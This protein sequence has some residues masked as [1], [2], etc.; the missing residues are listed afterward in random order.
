MKRI[1]E[2]AKKKGVEAEILMKEHQTINIQFQDGKLSSVTKNNLNDFSLRVLNNGKLGI[3]YG[4]KAKNREKL[5]D[6]AIDLSKAGS[7][8]DFPF[9]NQ[10]KF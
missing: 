8:V 10:A 7:K 4:S 6:A 9:S 3:I 5:V 1:I 2:L